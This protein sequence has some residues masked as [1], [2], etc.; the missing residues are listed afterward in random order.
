MSIANL[1]RPVR[2]LGLAGLLPQAACLAAVYI[3]PEDRFSA[4]A[5]GTFY[6]ALI[7]SFL[8]GL[9]WMQA[10]TAND[11]HWE[12]YVLAIVPSLAA[13]TLMLPWCF[14]WTWPGPELKALAALLAVSPLV[15]LRLARRLPQ[16]AGWLALRWRMA[17]GLA[18]LTLLLSLA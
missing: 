4:L 18:I 3:S 9:W 2:D 11:Q 14:G 12:P 1:P 8:G 15:D 5:A 13:W 6:P 7:L 17:T 10:L 16:P